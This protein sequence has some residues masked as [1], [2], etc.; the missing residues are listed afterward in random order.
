MFSNKIHFKS[1]G[2]KNRI[3]L[4]FGLVFVVVTTITSASMFLILNGQNT[5]TLEKQYE[6]KMNEVEL[7]FEKLEAFTNKYKE[8]KLK[9]KFEPEIKGQ[10]IVYAK[11]FDPGDEDFKYILHIKTT[12]NNLNQIALNTTG[13]NVDTQYIETYFKNISSKPHNILLSQDNKKSYF[14]IIKINKNINYLLSAAACG[15]PQ[16][17]CRGRRSSHRL[18]A[19]LKYAQR[20]H[21]NN[22]PFVLSL[23][24]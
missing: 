14:S 24:G 15:T 10:N 21:G 1:L 20:F 5:S 8:K 11:P 9:L 16:S 22:R 19:F 13:F 12:K 3:T 7:Y 6:L 4:T 18:Q 23:G 2:I 17:F